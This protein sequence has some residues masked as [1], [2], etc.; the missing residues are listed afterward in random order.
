[1]TLSRIAFSAILIIVGAVSAF[2]ATNVAFGGLHTLGL[3]GSTDYFAVTDEA[4]YALRDNHA[5]FYGGIFLALGLFLILAAT[6]VQRF[7]G[8]LYLAFVL[9]FAGGLA[10]LTQ[11]Q[12]EVTFGPSNLLSAI[13]ELALMPVLFIWLWRSS[14][15]S[16]AK[17]SPAADR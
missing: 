11:L 5:R 2:Y 4:T 13:V 7:R 9:V 17:V 12:P 16:V 8:G 1:M 3:Q 15:I 14:T 6:N 10:R